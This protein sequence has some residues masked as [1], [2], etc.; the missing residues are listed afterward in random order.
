[1]PATRRTPYPLFP[2]A[3]VVAADWY[4][5]TGIYPLHSVI[6]IRDLVQSEPRLP[7]ALYAALAESKRRHLAADPQW[8]ALPRLAR[9]ARRG[10]RRPR[11]LW[12]KRQQGQP[13]RASALL[14]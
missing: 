14:P 3:E 13:G 8:T 10:W 5:R 2:Q 6:A 1:M 7:T 4:L 9:Q 12:P 11:P